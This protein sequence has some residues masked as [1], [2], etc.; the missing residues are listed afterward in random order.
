MNRFREV[1]SLLH[2]PCEAMSRLASES[3]DRD[4]GRAERVVLGS[5]RLYC[6]ACRRYARQVARLRAGLRRLSARLD[7]DLIP[8]PDLPDDA[9]AR[10]KDAL[11]K[12]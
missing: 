7:D 4:L 5:H 12:R 9:R 8:G 11:S 1:W 2:L 6:G 3:L 10:I